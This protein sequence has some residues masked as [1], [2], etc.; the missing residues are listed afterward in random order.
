MHPLL[1]TSAGTNQDPGSI[2]VIHESK[3]FE[4]E[5]ESAG[6]RRGVLDESE[7]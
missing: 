1:R 3:N 5:E 6:S 7:S 2:R 4:R